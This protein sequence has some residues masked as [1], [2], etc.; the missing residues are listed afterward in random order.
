MNDS[1]I[2]TGEQPWLPNF[3]ISVGDTDITEKVRK[4]LIN[5]SL[6][7]YGGSNKQTDQI[8]VAI[9][10]ESLRIPARGVKVTLGLGFGTQI[11]NKGV[12]VVDGGSSGGEPRIV[13]FTAK[14]APMNSAKGL[15]TVQSKKTRSWT[16]NTLG[17][18]VAKVATDNGLKARVSGQFAGK[19][20]E[21]LDQVGESDANL[22]SRLADRFD[23]VSKV[24]GEYWMFLPRG[25]GESASGKPLKQYTL[26]RQGNSQWNYS[27]NGR[28]GDSGNSSSGNEDGSGDTSTYVIK[29]HDQASG[30]I[31]ELRSGTGD[32]VIEAPFVEPSL[33]AAQELLPG[34]SS[35]SKKK[36]VTMSHSM[37]ATLDLLSLTAECKITTTGFGTD[38][39]REWT[40]SNLNMT[41]GE[42]GFSIRLNLE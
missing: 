24:A 42:S 16:G 33:S 4:G 13:E 30:T 17:D 25:S 26:K 37:P 28:S 31:K 35:S 27:R 38:E 8:K 15:S 21:Q 40:I 3:F 36:E 22:V 5:I 14:A 18:I 2:N 29:Y 12:Y 11:V 6:D 9:V 19:V 20:I 39:D 32:P 34:V 23:A 41:L 10:S 7:D 1:R